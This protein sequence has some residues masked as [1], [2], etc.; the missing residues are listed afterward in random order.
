M[1]GAFFEAPR[2]KGNPLNSRPRIKGNQYVDSLPDIDQQLENAICLG[3]VTWCQE[4]IKKGA[5]VNCRVNQKGFTPLMLAVEGGWANVVRYLVENTPV[6]LELVD[7]GGFN[8]ADVAA[9]NGFLCAEEKGWNADV[10]DIANFLK[11]HGLEYTWRGAI[12]GGDV[13]RINEFLQNGQDIE[14]R[15]GYVCEGDYQ[16]TAFQMA[17]KYGRMSIA[18]YLLVRGACIPRDVCQM[19][20]PNEVELQ[21]FS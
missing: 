14:E 3:D 1:E 16:F 9:L 18:R 17:I 19:Q 8:V 6:D 4:C 12:L 10:A 5:N 15:V 11:D 20:L 2:K 21:G 7:V 13:D